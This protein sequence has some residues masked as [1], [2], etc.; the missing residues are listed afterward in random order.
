[1]Y[2]AMMK[3]LA[4]EHVRDMRVSAAKAERASEARRARGARRARRGAP[5]PASAAVFVPQP[6]Q[7]ADSALDHRH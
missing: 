3:A 2:P 7:S 5:A 4:A 6:R 1:M